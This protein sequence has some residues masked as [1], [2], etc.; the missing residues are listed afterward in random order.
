MLIRFT[1]LHRNL[2]EDSRSWFT[3]AAIFVEAAQRIRERRDEERRRFEWNLATH[4]LNG[5][6]IV[7]WSGERHQRR[8]YWSLTVGIALGT[9]ATTCAGI[10]ATRYYTSDTRLDLEAAP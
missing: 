9:D 7:E 3:Q 8:T 6:A 10:L 2:M 4:L 5:G 1:H